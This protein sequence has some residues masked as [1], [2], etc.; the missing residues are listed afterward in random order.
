MYIGNCGFVFQTTQGEMICGNCLSELISACNFKRRCI[1]SNKKMKSA[2]IMTI[3]NACNSASV[4]NEEPTISSKPF[5]NPCKKKNRA[6]SIK[7]LQST[8][9]IIAGSDKTLGSNKNID[10]VKGNRRRGFASKDYNKFA[11]QQFPP[12]T[13]TLSDHGSNGSLLRSRSADNV[14]NY[15]GKVCRAVFSKMDNFKKYKSQHFSKLTNLFMNEL[16]NPRAPVSSPVSIT[17]SPKTSTNL[18]EA[19]GVCPSCGKLFKQLNKHILVCPFVKQKGMKKQ[20]ER[21]GKVLTDLNKHKCLTE[22]TSSL[23]KTYPCDTCGKMYVVLSCA[24]LYHFILFAIFTN[25]Y[26]LHF[27]SRLN[28]YKS[29]WSHKKHVHNFDSNSKTK[30]DCLMCTKRFVK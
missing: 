15:Y 13:S 25:S 4:T 16:G 12:H 8:N 10:R 3:T 2:S 19:S 17:P 27:F 22:R 9:K 14:A 18:R 28:S 6:E 26:H 5:P 7:S 21:C 20:C 24:C 30:L 23:S 11:S 1:F 29:L